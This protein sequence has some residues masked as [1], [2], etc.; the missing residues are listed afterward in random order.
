[1]IC[2]T[3]YLQVQI[4]ESNL[5]GMREPLGRLPG[6][7]WAIS[8][9]VDDLAGEDVASPKAADEV[10][11]EAPSFSP[12]FS[13]SS[14]RSISSSAESRYVKEWRKR[15]GHRSIAMECDAMLRRSV[16]DPATPISGSSSP[17][18]QTSIG[19]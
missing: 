4:F 3:G 10:Q 8:T 6:R 11:G 9:P 7:F 19:S 15:I 13:P 12:S 5:I 1:V 17:P 2:S 18:K 14:N 16:W